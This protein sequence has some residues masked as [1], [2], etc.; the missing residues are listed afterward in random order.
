MEYF[1]SILD[2]SVLEKEFMLKERMCS[3]KVKV[4]Y[5]LM[6]M[7]TLKNRGPPFPVHSI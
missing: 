6:A 4:S 3:L 5:I 1:F 7:G 2:K